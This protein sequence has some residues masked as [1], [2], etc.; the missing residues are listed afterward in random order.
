MDHCIS[1]LQECEA[2]KKDPLYVNFIREPKNRRWKAKIYSDNSKTTLDQYDF[3]DIL[4]A[5]QD[6]KEELAKG[7][8]W[9]TSKAHNSRYTACKALFSCHDGQVLRANKL[10]WKKIDRWCKYDL[11]KENWQGP[12]PP[13]LEKNDDLSF[14]TEKELA[15]FKKLLQKLEQDGQKSP[16]S[17]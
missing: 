6:M 8:T 2:L 12:I 16:V 13:K 5:Y 9:Y 17:C 14:W 11:N 3:A 4:N 10:D 1:D 7:E 15:N